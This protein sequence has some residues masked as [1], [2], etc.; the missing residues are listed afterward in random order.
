MPQIEHLTIC[1]SEYVGGLEIAH[2]LA[3]VLRM[4]IRGNVRGQ[5]AALSDFFRVEHFVG[6]RKSTQ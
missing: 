4:T 6:G 2:L 3:D 5:V 1:D